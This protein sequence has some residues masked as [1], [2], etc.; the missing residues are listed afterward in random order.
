[1]PIPG[2]RLVLEPRHPVF[3]VYAEIDAQG[4]EGAYTCSNDDVNEETSFVNSFYSHKER[5]D[6]I[7]YK[8]NGKTLWGRIPALHHIKQDIATIGCSCAWSM[9]S[10]IKAMDTLKGML[11]PHIYKMYFLSGMFMETSKRSGVT[12]VFRRLRP[13]VALRPSKDGT[14]MKILCCLCMHPIG[15]YAETW[16]GAMCPTDDVMSHLLLMRSD[17]KMFWKRCNQITPHRPEAGL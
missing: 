12:Y 6:I 10:E 13:T 8:V 9:D 5:C 7:I 15:Y 1:M 16:A 3:S 11:P 14:D 17:E 2:E 4:M